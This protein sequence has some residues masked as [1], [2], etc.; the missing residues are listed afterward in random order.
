[1]NSPL[2]HIMGVKEAGEMWGLSA[3]RVKGLC[4]SGEVIAKKV[5]NSWILDKNQPN[6]K[7]GR[8]VRKEEVFTVT[9]EDQPGTPYP[10]K[11]KEVDSEQEAI[12][13]AEKWADEHKSEFIYINYYRASDGQQGYLNPDGYNVNG[14]DWASKYK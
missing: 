10:T 1:M 13:L 6:P 7:G 11:H 2:E 14:Q 12:E 3:D 8:R 5:G 9:I 4:Q